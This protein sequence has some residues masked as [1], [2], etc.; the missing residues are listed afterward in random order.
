MRPGILSVVVYSSLLLLLLLLVVFLERAKPHRQCGGIHLDKTTAHEAIV[1]IIIIIIITCHSHF[2]Y[3]VEQLDGPIVSPL[4]Q[5][6]AELLE[7][8]T[9]FLGNDT[10]A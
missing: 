9:H 4:E 5:D 8:M 1:I 6:N 7:L 3:V 10:L 2:Q